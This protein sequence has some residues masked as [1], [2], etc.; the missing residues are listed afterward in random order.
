V[1]V[2]L[3]LGSTH[4]ACTTE[5]G[6][7]YTWGSGR[8]GRL[9]H[10]DRSDKK[11]PTLVEALVGQVVEQLALGG[12]H[13]ACTTEEGTLY[14]W[15]NDDGGR[16][17]HGVG[18]DK[19]VPTLVEALVG[20][21][22]VQLALGESHSACTTEEGTLYTW[23][24]GGGRQLGHGDHSDKNVPTLVEALVGQVVVQLALGSSHSACITEEGTL[25]TWGWGLMGQMGHGHGA[26]NVY[27][28]TPVG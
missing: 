23:G 21:V 13:S 19:N 1:V 26:K 8:N 20:Q 2:Q 24:R 22:V 10:G 3:A 6:T 17:G 9:G 5:E 15:G 16:L 27:V 12:D 18:F 4:S 25:Y 11:V 28:P 14:T 7:L